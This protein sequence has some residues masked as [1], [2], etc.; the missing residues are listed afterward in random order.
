[1]PFLRNAKAYIIGDEITVR[2]SND[3]A[4]SRLDNDRTKS[5]IVATVASLTGK[6]YNVKIE[7]GA[8]IADAEDEIFDEILDNAEEL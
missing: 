1:M 6:K 3:F 2:V 4:L 7:V 5:V 8:A